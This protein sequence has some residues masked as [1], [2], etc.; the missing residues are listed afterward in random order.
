MTDHDWF[1]LMV[2]MVIGGLS[3]LAGYHLGGCR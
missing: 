1:V 3:V 2:G